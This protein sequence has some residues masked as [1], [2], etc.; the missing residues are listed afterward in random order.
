MICDLWVDPTLG[1]LKNS[2]AIIGRVYFYF[3]RFYLSMKIYLRKLELLKDAA[4]E[5]FSRSSTW[6]NECGSE[7][8]SLVNGFSVG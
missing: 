8:E 1:S 3:N 2:S 5:H 6:R 7:V 4:S